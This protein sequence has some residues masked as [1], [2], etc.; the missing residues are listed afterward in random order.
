MNQ[1]NLYNE[2]IEKEMLAI[3]K[4]FYKFYETKI[5]DYQRKAIFAYRDMHYINYLLLGKDKS[6]EDLLHGTYPRKITSFR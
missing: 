5:T 4:F 2:K 1:S 3:I 6:L